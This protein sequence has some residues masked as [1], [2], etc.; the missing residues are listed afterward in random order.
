MQKNFVVD[1]EEL[2]PAVNDSPYK[3][4]LVIGDVHATVDKLSLLWQ[5]LDVTENDFVIFLGDYLNFT[6]A[7][8]D[9]QTLSWIIDQSDK[10]NFIFLRGNAEDYLLK[11][12]FD[13]SQ[14]VID[15][16][17][18]MP[19]HYEITVGG[20]KFFFCH[21]G[22]DPNSPLDRQDDDSLVWLYGCENFYTDYSGDAVIV[23]GHKSPKKIFTYFPKLFVN[24]KENI[25]LTE[26]TRLPD[27][28]ILLLDTRAKDTDGFL[29][30]V[31]IFSGEFWQS[32]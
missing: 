23:V 4:L 31:D 12:D 14:G 16:L 5:K 32:N 29:S 3:R 6:N 20:K 11:N 10:K 9:V 19:T 15:F 21:A 26:P 28:N 1:I 2:L 27:K 30:C 17:D 8:N 7:D 24:A 13:L 25:C 18:A 22:I